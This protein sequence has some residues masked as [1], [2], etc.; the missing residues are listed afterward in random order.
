MDRFLVYKTTHLP[1]GRYYIGRH[2]TSKL[3][4]GYYGSGVYISKLLEAYP[5]QEFKREILLDASSADEMLEVE[6]LLI[7]MCLDTVGC[8]NLAQGDPRSGGVIRHS[9]LTRQKMSKSQTGRKAWNKGLRATS[10]AIEKNR[11]SHLGKPATKGST[12]HKHTEESLAKM[13]GRK[14]VNRK[15]STSTETLKA[16]LLKA[17]A[18]GGALRL[19]AEKRKAAKHV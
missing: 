11:T 1:S 14:V 19:A 18:P 4:D 12:G 2:V 7:S 10:E 5:R 8:I 16:S 15:P 13:R 6:D 3:D 17:W 9:L